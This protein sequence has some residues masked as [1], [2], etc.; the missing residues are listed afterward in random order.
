M[1]SRPAEILYPIDSLGE[2]LVIPPEAH[3]FAGFR[4]WSQSDEFPERGRTD[5][6]AGKIEVDMS[7][8]D[9]YT[10]GAVKTAIAALYAAAG[11]PEFWLIDARGDDVLFGIYQLI[12]GPYRRLPLDADGWIF[13][14]LLTRRV[15]LIRTRTPLNRWAYELEHEPAG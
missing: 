4:R 15:R 7:P 5:F 2:E 12:D 6:L 9:L 10:H 1:A 11:V 3:S 8:E 13:S 14:P